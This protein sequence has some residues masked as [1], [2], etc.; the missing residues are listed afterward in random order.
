MCYLGRDYEVV[1]VC[2]IVAWIRRVVCWRGGTLDCTYGGGMGVSE[3][4]LPREPCGCGDACIVW[5]HWSVP[6]AAVFVASHL[7]VGVYS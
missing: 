6:T 2:G 1:N 4:W 3:P 5:S 7:R